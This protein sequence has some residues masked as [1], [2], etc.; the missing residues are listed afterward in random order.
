MNVRGTPRD[1]VGGIKKECCAA[2]VWQNSLERCCGSSS[3]SVS[4][5]IT[6]EVTLLLVFFLSDTSS[7]RNHVLPS[8]EPQFWS[9]CMALSTTATICGKCVKWWNWRW[10]NKVGGYRTGRR[11]TSHIRWA[12]QSVGKV[13]EENFAIGECERKREPSPTPRQTRTTALSFCAPLEGETKPN[14]KQHYSKRSN[15]RAGASNPP[16]RGGRAGVCSGILQ[17]RLTITRCFQ[18]VRSWAL[19]CVMWR[20][21]ACL[22][23]TRVAYLDEKK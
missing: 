17:L 19:V 2:R 10:R 22:V 23:S 14:N 21:G 9:T 20:S 12:C 6:C 18:R 1:V 15:E 13:R 5:L 4:Y 11:S 7:C 8:P 16:R 3:Q